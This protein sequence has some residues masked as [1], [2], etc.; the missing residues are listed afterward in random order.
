MEGNKKQQTDVI[1]I[2]KITRSLYARKKLFFIVLP[3]VFVLSSIYIFSLPRYYTSTVKLAPE[4][5]N[6]LAEGGLSSLASSFGFD[7]GSMNTSDAIFPELYPE[8]LGTNDFITRFFNV[9]VEDEACTF[10]TDYY[11]YLTTLRKRPWWSPITDFF[12]GI[13]KAILPKAEDEETGNTAKNGTG[14]GN[15]FNPLHLTKKQN[16]VAEAIKGSI[17]CNIDRKTSLITIE[18]TDQDRRI[19]AT[20]ADSIRLKIQELIIDYRTHKARVDVEYYQK[21]T[22]EAKADYEKARLAY[23]HFADGNRNAILESVTSKRDDLEKDMSMK[24][25][26]YTTYNGQLQAA[27]AKLQQRTPSFTL[28]QGASV[29]VRP[30]GPKRVRFIFIMM[31]LACIGLSG[32][33]F[34]KDRG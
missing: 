19:C 26:N 7:I 30:V 3:I 10:K 6:S 16:D 12:N 32:Y 28:L 15:T 14:G 8:L 24:Y 2:G 17:R 1:D 31:F 18:V 22:E 11:T 33:I 13:V 34:V 23:T 20:I 25:T 9:T 27:V 29:P 5:D 4:T 21:L